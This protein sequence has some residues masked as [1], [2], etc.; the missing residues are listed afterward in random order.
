[1]ERAILK[2]FR[3]HNGNASWQHLLDAGL[4]PAK[5]KHRAAT[6]ELTRMFPGVYAHGD[7]ALIP[8]CHE[9]AALLSLG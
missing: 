8:F 7:P 1:M 3:D 4:T 6:G 9:A 5:I 2:L